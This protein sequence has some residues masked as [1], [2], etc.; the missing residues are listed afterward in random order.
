MNVRRR[1][2]TLALLTAA[3][4]AADLTAQRG[5]RRPGR[6]PE[7]ETTTPAREETPRERKKVERWT[8][9]RGGDV[10]IGDGTVLRRASVLIGDDRIEAVGH[11][12]EVPEGATILDATGKVV[13]PGFCIVKAG[14]MGAPGG[15]SD[16]IADAVNPFDPSMKLGLAAGIT[17]FC[18]LYE[19]GSSTAGGKSAIVKLAYGDLK[20]MVAV[21]GSVATMRVPLDPQKMKAFR[22]LVE[23]AKD[24]RKKLAEGAAAPSAAERS[25]ATPPPEGQGSA[26]PARGGGAPKPPAGTEKL[27]EIM[28][29]KTRLW[30]GAAG[31]FDVPEIRQALEIANLL[32]VGVVLDD[33]VTAWVVADEIAASGS[34]AI[35]APRNRTR[36][37]PGR[38]DTSGS[39]IASAAILSAVGVPVAVTPPG[40]RFGSAG[41]GTGGI[42]GQDLNTPHVD[43]AFAVRGGMDNRAAL[44]TITLD[45]ARI[46]GVDNRVGSLEAGKDADVLILDGDPLHYKTFVE[47]ALVNGKV[48]YEKDKEP[49][50]RHIKR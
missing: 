27:I 50:Y 8:A 5:R 29:G 44:R 45:A 26:A 28:D 6:Q 1:I 43:A 48:V 35:L 36:A 41:V 11:D 31:D 20:G 18:A 39:N 21:E 40:G 2:L 46:M 15:S 19:P 13:S 9:I 49:F 24:F 37:D 30:I 23:Q 17:S 4:C 33:P 25:G 47:I 10:Y 7:A 38:P 22:D 42:L 12:L 14:G 34:M 16:R 32:G 3:V